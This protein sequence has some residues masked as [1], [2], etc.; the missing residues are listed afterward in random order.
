[1]SNEKQRF[2]L[3][4]EQMRAEAAR[5]AEVSAAWLNTG[6][7]ESQWQY[8]CNGKAAYTL[9]AQVPALLDRIAELERDAGRLD[10][11]DSCDQFIYSG[12][13]SP[14]TARAAIDAAMQAQSVDLLP[15]FSPPLPEGSTATASLVDANIVA[16]KVNLSEAISREPG[17]LKVRVNE[18]QTKENTK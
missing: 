12:R 11:V 10:F 14:L 5:L 18:A 17:M 16:V 1:M 4:A 3:T 15:A 13:T 7:I 6:T 9:A 2:E 8:A